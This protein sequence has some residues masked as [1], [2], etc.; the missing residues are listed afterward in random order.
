M[1]RKKLKSI[2][3]AL[4]MFGL[5]LQTLAQVQLGQ[6]IHGDNPGD[7]SGTGICMSGDGNRVAIAASTHDDPEIDAGQ[8][9]IYEYNGVNWNQL[10]K[11]IN[12]EFEDH[13]FGFGHGESVAMSYSGNHILIGGRGSDNGF[14]A[15]GS[16]VVYEYDGIGSWEKIAKFNGEKIQSYF[17]QSV[18]ISNDGT[19]IAIG[20]R[21]HAANAGYVVA[22]ELND[23]GNWMPY[24][25]PL[26]ANAIDEIYG[27]SVSM[28]GTGTYLAVGAT[29]TDT[30][31]PE[32]GAVYVYKFDGVNWVQL[33]NIIEG[34]ATGDLFGYTT[35]LTDDLTIAIGAPYND[36][37]GISAGQTRIYR[38]NAGV[39]IQLGPE[40][41]GTPHD[42]AGSSVDIS[43]FGAQ[44]RLSVGIPL[45]DIAGVNAG[46]T[47]LYDFNGV[48]WNEIF[49][50]GVGGLVPGTQKG[51][52]VSLSVDGNRVAIG[53]PFSNIN[54]ALTGYGEV[55]S[56]LPN[57]PEG[58]SL[59]SVNVYPNPT[60]DLLKINGID[61][62]TKG[63]MTFMNMKG[64]VVYKT[65]L[66]PTLNL[67][68][69]EGS[70]L[71]IIQ[72]VEGISKEFRLEVK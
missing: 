69:K 14:Y 46:M 58:F 71:L 26:I 45:N 43:S 1:I 50:P 32:T 65:A 53:A 61:E 15:S 6:T 16:A 10:G 21:G 8:I 34:Q 67:P 20:A 44:T 63:T 55:Y 27:W 18:D 33:G 64:E 22:Y 11:D 48:I 17:G 54:G 39:W 57:P 38:Y 31:L 41:D 30:G 62:E 19:K 2:F 70:Y 12:G 42:F 5:T 37:G 3:V 23:A 40:I 36:A 4:L 47:K 24:G 60:S 68:L 56:L 66:K 59:M 25:Q 29:A 9:R 51:R 49:F 28:D 13:A 7:L 35:S 72:G 52:S